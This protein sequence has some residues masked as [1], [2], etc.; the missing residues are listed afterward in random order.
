[1]DDVLESLQERMEYRFQD[2][3]LLRK[4]LTHA[5][6]AAD[7]L[8]SNERLEFLGDSV[9]GLAVA[10]ELF[11]LSPGR[12]VGEMTAVKSAVV[13]RQTMARVA[14][15]LQLQDCLQVDKGLGQRTAFPPSL[16]ANAY[17]AVTGA[18]FLD[19]GFDEA[20]RFVLRTLRAELEE[21]QD[22]KLC[23][24]CKS[25]LQQMVQA[26]GRRPP[27]YKMEKKIGPDHDTSFLAVVKIGRL[28]Y[29]GTWGKTKKAAE[30]SAAKEALDK[31]Y[32]DWKEDD[33]DT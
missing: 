15:G 26:E 19:S 2:I 5:S 14:R 13:S 10:E 33:T 22:Q 24:S 28:S 11:R 4:A 20:A 3:R 8:G 29:S 25:L 6:L 32:P 23:I 31:L 21:L 18:I 1:M 17:E 16:L 7:G 27:A 9:A 30:E 12:T